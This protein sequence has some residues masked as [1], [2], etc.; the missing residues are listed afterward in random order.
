MITPKSQSVTWFRSCR[1][2]CPAMYFLLPTCILKSQS[3]GTNC[4]HTGC[5]SSCSSNT[6]ILTET[7]VSCSF[8]SPLIE[9]PCLSS[10]AEPSSG[11]ITSKTHVSSGGS[12]S[13]VNISLGICFAL[14]KRRH[15]AMFHF[16]FLLG[17][18][19]QV[20]RVEE[21]GL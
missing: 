21:Q 11:Q 6:Q 5:F 14:R 13:D 20:L 12:P 15:P 9:P 18:P 2:L 19:S 16:L 3:R 10:V 8:P 17:H 7:W 1:H 4:P